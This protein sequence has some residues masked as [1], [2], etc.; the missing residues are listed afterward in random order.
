MAPI[1][2]SVSWRLV[3]RKRT[4]EDNVGWKVFEFFSQGQYD[5]RHLYHLIN[6]AFDRDILPA[7]K[8]FTAGQD[9]GLEFLV[10]TEP[11]EKIRLDSGLDLV[12]IFESSFLPGQSRKHLRPQLK[13]CLKRL[14]RHQQQGM[15]EKLTV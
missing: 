13:D 15:V 4:V 7:H 5:M 10:E 3:D 8:H 9:V 11:G 14:M 12:E 1:I 2:K 6:L